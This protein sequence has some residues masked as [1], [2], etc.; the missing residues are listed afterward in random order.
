[1]TH[2][3]TVEEAELMQY[4]MKNKTTFKSPE[5]VK[6]SYCYL[7]PQG[8][9]SEDEIQN[10]VSK[11][12][13]LREVRTIYGMSLKFGSLKKAADE[14]KLD[15]KETD[16]FEKG[17][18]PG[19]L[20]ENEH[21]VMGINKL[22]LND[23]SPVFQWKDGYVIVQVIEAVSSMIKPFEEVQGEIEEK[24]KM[25]KSVLFAEE[26]AKTVIDELARG[27]HWDDVVENLNQKTE[28]TGYFKKMSLS[29]PNAGVFPDSYGIFFGLSTKNPYVKSPVKGSGKFY[30]F[31]LKDMRVN[32]E[33][34][35]AEQEKFK[36]E[37][38][39]KK[40]EDVFRDWLEVM[41]EKYQV[42]VLSRV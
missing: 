29:V 33:T 4:Y 21:I 9:F 15:V 10:G 36:R 6:L 19:E 34:Y 38:L 16:F 22:K 41:K 42:K 12:A 24:L 1:Y 30:V 17:I 20:A 8:L 27:E 35:E 18:V 23:I 3:V 14:K 32:M 13:V 2:E 5:K 28:T 37:L 39:R 26:K 7:T 40:Q 25:E 11:E 31:C